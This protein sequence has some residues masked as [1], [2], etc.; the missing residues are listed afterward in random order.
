M[1]KAGRAAHIRIEGGV[2]GVGFRVFIRTRAS[3]AGL[4]GWVANRR[5]GAVEALLIGDPHEVEKVLEA[6]RRGP[7]HADVSGFSILSR[8]DVDLAGPAG[9]DR[10]FSIRATF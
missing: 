2:Q 10:G 1:S 9:E 6:C 8:E 5:D 7:R 4:S 3:E